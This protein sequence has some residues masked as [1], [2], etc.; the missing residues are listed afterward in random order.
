MCLPGDKR[1]AVNNFEDV[2]AMDRQIS[3]IDEPYERLLRKVIPLA[4][5]QGPVGL[6]WYLPKGGGAAA[7]LGLAMATPSIPAVFKRFW[8]TKQVML[9]AMTLML[10]ACTVGRAGEFAD[11]GSLT[12]GACGGC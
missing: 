8:L 3:C 4:F 11:G 1:V 7:V 10:A 9:G 6:G 2:L 5:G 12:K